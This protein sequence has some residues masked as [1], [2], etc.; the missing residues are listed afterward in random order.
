MNLFFSTTMVKKIKMHNKNR[1]M[2]IWFRQGVGVTGDQV[3][4]PEI[5]VTSGNRNHPETKIMVTS[6]NRLPP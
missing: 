3:P 6:G 4:Y 2:S 1:I 5:L